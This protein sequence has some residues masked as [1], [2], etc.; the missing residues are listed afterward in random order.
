MLFPGVA[1]PAQPS[2][3]TCSNC[4]KKQQCYNK[5]KMQHVRVQRPFICST[6]KYC[7]CDEA[8]WEVHNCSVG[9]RLDYK[10]N[11]NII[12]IVWYF[13]DLFLVLFWRFTT[14]VSFHALYFLCFFVS[15]L[16][17][18][19]LQYMCSLVSRS[20]LSLPVCHITQC[21]FHPPYAVH[22]VFFGLCLCIWI[23]ASSLIRSVCLVSCTL[24]GYIP[25]P[26]MFPSLAT[27]AVSPKETTWEETRKWFKRN[28]MSFSLT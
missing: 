1:L 16:L 25:I 27:F 24:T 15:H 20:A 9:Y 7:T 3:I 17:W 14:L 4:R 10:L 28:E 22:P 5:A 13:V 19:L 2:S 12:V 8:C 26:F 6:E 18:F 23:F 11:N 21:A